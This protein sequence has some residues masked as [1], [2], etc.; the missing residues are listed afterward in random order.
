[1][2]S[3]SLQNENKSA[4]LSRLFSPGLFRQLA[5]EGQSSRLVRLLNEAELLND[6]ASKNLAQVF[7]EAFQISQA[8]NLRSEQVYKAAITHKVLLGTHS[9]KT[10]SLFTEFRVGNSKADVVV[11]NGTSTVYEIKSE[12]DS[13]ERLESQLA[14]YFQ[15]FSRV[16]VICAEKHV[17]KVLNCTPASVGIL[18]LNSRYQISTLRE[19]TDCDK[20]V[21]KAVLFDSLSL[22]EAATIIER[23]GVQIP[24][25]PN[26]SK[27]Q[28]MKSIFCELPHYKLKQEA[29]KALRESR[30]VEHLSDFILQLPRSLQPLG[31][32]TRIRKTDQDR[33]LKTIN[34]PAEN[35]LKWN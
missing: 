29:V 23:L 25:V 27:Y 15:V 30:S 33:L 34:Q 19:A 18:T 7:D 3:K 13:L 9:L 17:Q 31:V 6:L 26:T 21:D 35:I 1:M 22:T 32:T 5:R 11:V 20:R 4:A 12:K 24:D 8:K 10:A 2:T 16:N 14:D 28:V